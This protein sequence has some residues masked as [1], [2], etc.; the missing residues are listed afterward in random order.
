MLLQNRSKNWHEQ[1]KRI[2]PLLPELCQANFR[3]EVGPELL[4]L[5]YYLIGVFVFDVISILCIM[6]SG[7]SELW[8]SSHNCN[9]VSSTF[10]FPGIAGC[11][12]WTWLQMQILVFGETRVAIF[13]CV[14]VLPVNYLVKAAEPSDLHVAWAQLKILTVWIW[15]PPLHTNKWCQT[16]FVSW[17]C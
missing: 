4:N 7:Y 8:E 2:V 13:R 11:L 1:A 15:F 9:Y 10:V 5:V 16:K 12:P 14:I 3:I 6:V 17:W